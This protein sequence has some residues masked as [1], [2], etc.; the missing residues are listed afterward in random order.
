MIERWNEVVRPNDRVRYGGDLSMGVRRSFDLAELLARL[1]G[2]KE[3]MPGNHDEPFPMRSKAHK[4]AGA[5]M[6]AG[7]ETVHQDLWMDIEIG[8]QKFRW[9]HFPYGPEDHS[10]EVRY[11]ECRPP[12]EGD[13]LICGHIHEKWKIKDRMINIGVDQWDFYPVSEEQIL[14]I[15]REAE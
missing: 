3:L 1:N 10:S 4:W 5:Y 2:V 9:S 8:G 15:V 12:D 7:F 11:V 13:W 6:L 14:E